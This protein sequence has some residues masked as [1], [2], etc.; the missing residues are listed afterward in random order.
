MATHVKKVSNAVKSKMQIF[1]DDTSDPNA[2]VFATNDLIDVKGSLGRDAK[3]CKVIIEGNATTY[4]IQFNY[5]LTVSHFNENQSD[6]NVDMPVDLSNINT[7]R[8][9]SLASQ[10]RQFEFAFPITSIRIV[11]ATGS[12]AATSHIHFI[13]W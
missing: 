10:I 11:A 6:N 13:L 4:T 3:G 5:E 8:F 9:Y 1:T 12:A 7:F 2:V